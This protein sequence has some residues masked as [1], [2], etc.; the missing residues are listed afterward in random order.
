MKNIFSIEDVFT[1]TGRGT[2]ATGRMI[3]GDVKTGDHLFMPDGNKVL[4]TGIEQFVK[5][6]GIKGDNL[7]LLLRGVTKEYMSGFRKCQVEV[8][9]ISEIRDR[10]LNELGI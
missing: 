3:S 2:V 4:I 5:S 9:D 6:F 10:K 1:I 7:G 8:G